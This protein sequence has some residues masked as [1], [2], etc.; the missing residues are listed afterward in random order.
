MTPANP[1]NPVHRTAQLTGLGYILQG[2][3]L[4]W[5]P[6]IR[7]FVLIPLLIN[8]LLFA[9]GTWAVLHYTG[10]WVDRL[11]PHWLEF[12]YWLIMPLL[13]VGLML[14]AY[15][16]FTVVANLIA[17]PFNAILAQKLE[18]QLTGQ[19][20]P[21]DDDSLWT[22][23]VETVGAE[24]GKMWYFVVRAI[25][26]LIL[27]LIPGLNLFAP[28]LWFAFSAWMMTLQYLDSPASNHKV[29][30]HRQRWLLRRVPT[31]TL[32]FGATLT[33]MTMV[34]VLNFLSLPVGVCGA[35]KLWV[36][37]FRQSS[38]RTDQDT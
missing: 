19:P 7:R 4:M 10:A 32:G 16:T 13:F 12:L 11:L 20:T 35:T 27:F 36:D 33:F 9:G 1:T 21:A 24:L 15:F 26:L 37:R 34:P 22:L 18:E 29:D 23:T 17:A 31:T 30:F 38:D 8:I 5:R 2:F 28:L 14:V 25:P 3:S 6:G